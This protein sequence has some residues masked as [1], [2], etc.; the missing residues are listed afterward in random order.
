MGE[1]ARALGAV[2][3]LALRALDVDLLATGFEGGLEVLH[4]ARHAAG[5]GQPVQR[6]A[7]GDDDQQDQRPAQRAVELLGLQLFV[8]Q[9]GLAVG[10][11]LDL[12]ADLVPS[13]P[14]VGDDVDGHP[15]QE[16]H[17]DDGADGGDRAGSQHGRERE[18]VHQWP[19]PLQ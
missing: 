17:H 1:N 11:Q 7:H 3:V 19:P 15:H 10:G 12:G 16:Q 18:Q 14:E 4:R 8:A 9:V 13:R 2:A 6:Q 5:L